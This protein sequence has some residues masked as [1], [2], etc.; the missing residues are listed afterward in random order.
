MEINLSEEDTASIK[1]S[2]GRTLRDRKR[3]YKHKKT[4]SEI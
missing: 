1:H 2:E 4:N 3:M